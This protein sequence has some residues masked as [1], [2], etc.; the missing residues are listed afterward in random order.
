MVTTGK[1][2]DCAHRLTKYSGT[3]PPLW[4]HEIEHKEMLQCTP[5]ADVLLD[6]DEVE[7]LDS[8]SKSDPLAEAGNVSGVAIEADN[9]PTVD[10]VVPIG[11]TKR[12]PS[13]PEFN[14]L[15]IVDNN[16][17]LSVPAAGELPVGMHDTHDHAVVAP[18]NL[19]TN[20]YDPMYVADLFTDMTLDTSANHSTVS[21]LM[22]CF[23]K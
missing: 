19:S 6:N 15:E 14:E 16:N 1:R 11:V 5:D 13:Q 2:R 22:T 23:R 17:M 10:N 21:W 12:G 7:L 20:E 9:N 4:K 8:I 3:V 18:G